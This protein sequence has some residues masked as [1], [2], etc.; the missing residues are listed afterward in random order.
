MRRLCRRAPRACA[1]QFQFSG[2]GTSLRFE[3]LE[4]RWMLASDLAA[5]LGLGANSASDALPALNGTAEILGMKW[6][7]LNGNGERND[8]E[9]GLAG[10][11]IYLD[12]NDDGALGE[13]EPRTLT[14]ED[15]PE[16]LEDE[17]GNYAFTELMPGTYI[18]RE[19]VPT[20]YE[21]TFPLARESEFEIT[22]VFPDNSLSAEQQEFFT[23][24]AARWSEIILGDLPDVN[25]PGFGLVD[26]LVI[27]ATGP[28][29]DGP[30]GILGQ[31]GPNT[32]RSGS[33]LP[34]SGVME[35]DQADI[36]NLIN[37]GRFG[38]VILHEMGHVLGIGTIWDNLNLLTG[39]G[40]TNPQFIGPQATVE[41][42]AIF[43]ATASSVPVE[44]DQGGGGTLYAHW[45]EATLDNEL[46]TG[47]LN[48][49]EENPLSRITVGQ[50]ADL[51]YDV[52]L[53]AAD[54]YAAPNLRAASEDP[55]ERRPLG[56]IGILRFDPMILEPLPAAEAATL[57][58]VAAPNVTFWT[59]ELA[60]GEIV[61]NV[62]FGNMPLP[63]SISGVK[64]N[65]RNSDG[66]RD[67]NEPPIAGWTIF[68]DDNLN[69]QLD[70]AEESY[71]AEDLPQDIL[72]L[73]T[74]TSS[75]DVEGLFGGVLDV[76]VTIDVTHSFDADLDIFLIS[77]Q[78]TRI[79]LATNIGGSGN[80][81]SIT[82]FDDEAGV[83]ITASTAPFNGT[84]RPERSL[85]TLDGENPNG[86]WRLEIVDEAFLDEGVFRSWSITIQAG[87]RFT[88]TD[89]N[90]AYS[91]LNLPAGDYRVAEVQQDD[92]IQTYPLEPG[93][94][95][96][97]LV[98]GE[99]RAG[100]DFGNRNGFIGGQLWND[101][102]GD[103]VRDEGEPPLAGWT[104]YLDQNNNGVLDDGPTTVESSGGAINILD[105]GTIESQITV[106]NLAFIRDLDVTINI[107]HPYDSDLD[108]FLVSPSGTRIELFTDVG[109]FGDN[110]H[111][112]T[113]DDEADAA[114]GSGT[115]PF[116]G[117]F[118][119]EG[120]LSAVDG[121]NPNGVWTLEVTD[122][123]FADVGSL[124]SWSLTIVTRE[125]TS[126]TDA[127]GAYAFEDLRAATY[128]VSGVVE[129]GWV[130]TLPVD[131][132]R[133]EISLAAGEARFGVDFANRTGALRG[134]KWNDRNADGTR[135]EG[136][137]GL[138]GWTIYLDENGNGLFDSGA[139]TIE[140][141]G[142][143]VAIPDLGTLDSTILVDG[144]HRID[145]LNVSL[146]IVHTYVADL[147]VFLI[148][149]SGTRVE[150]FT[151]LAA[152][153]ENFDGTTLDD[154]ASRLL[155]T[156][157][158]PFLGAYRP[159]GSLAD[160][161]GEDPNGVWTLEIT[162]DAGNDFG[163]LKG[164]S[165]TITSHESFTTTGAD[166]SYE[167][168]DVLPASYVVREVNQTNWQP[169]FP[170]TP[171]GHL[172]D[173]AAGE[174]R[175]ALDFGARATS[176]LGDYDQDGDVDGN[177]FLFWQQNLGKVADPAGS[178]ADGDNN[179]TIDAG[180]LA[181][182][183]Q[184]FGGIL[185]ANEASVTA[186]ALDE[187]IAQLDAA[188]LAGLGAPTQDLAPAT[189]LRGMAP[190]APSW[191]DR[192]SADRAA[193]SAP[194]DPHDGPQRRD[195]PV[196]R[197]A[198]APDADQGWDLVA[199]AVLAAGLDAI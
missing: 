145:D 66:V 182:W 180:D 118:R 46:M 84:F 143:P 147:D 12:L 188:A 19:L 151:D 94:Y 81:F 58:S 136:E 15:N 121:E 21:Q 138:S 83:S 64:W 6:S 189:P 107:D 148:S 186:L 26:D 137:P 67:E 112:T 102:N 69:G 28:S 149:P 113:L 60:D 93:Y 5:A 73:E 126:I 171:G 170:G 2:F 44:G 31:A 76:N 89:A 120:L 110:F 123:T 195:A 91:F 54:D 11:T 191:L 70:Y 14:A 161:D 72:D 103:G 82:T 168:L 194:A 192:P 71:Q 9:P 77:P 99:E 42:N 34:S 16:T 134:V 25:V 23:A 101:Y 52:N 183:D 97:T 169:T 80:N 45:D 156:G 105:Q 175:G 166:G 10:V 135:E 37:N 181:I 59:V 116:S 104:V 152:P 38:D 18:V 172:F 164:W 22:I 78:G 155:T 57:A 125:A 8:N 56:R 179:G 61:E 1:T 176:L 4:Q 33:F 50:M 36:L 96:V 90:G 74:T 30:G 24:A 184:G 128:Y 124:V 150:L 111:G 196:R 29:I 162:D 115:A 13:D 55:A 27:E 108:V 40:S 88:T 43:G 167:F 129:P 133:Y 122:D 157:V 153:G 197:S 187:A 190:A 109:T 198:F 85:A 79:A 160:F 159:F 177:D 140:S 65:D 63:G 154:E 114:I 68:L 173:L 165:L 98:P 3:P 185:A 62:D 95:D 53:N 117:R 92:Y 144:Q 127:E 131:T 199:D 142:D 48:S 178:G 193:G 141:V 49:G 17:T 86:Q 51:G 47:F 158:G 87:E 7:D 20:G 39:F 32:L 75:I 100:V 35:F 106:E 139:V 163:T 119:P 146:S 41:Y 130:Q 132:G 174:Q